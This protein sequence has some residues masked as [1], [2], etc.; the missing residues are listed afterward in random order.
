MLRVSARRAA[1][2]SGP[3]AVWGMATSHNVFVL[4]KDECEHS[5]ETLILGN[6]SIDS[7]TG[8]KDWRQRDAGES[9]P[10]GAAG[11]NSI[12]IMIGFVLGA[13]LNQQSAL[14]RLVQQPRTRHKRNHPE[15]RLAISVR[16]G[17]RAKAVQADRLGV[18]SHFCHVSSNA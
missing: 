16:L 6:T 7:W 12:T 5:T 10:H 8:I 13:T 14:A 18:S 15:G 17:H 11:C 2:A 9:E 3:D 1:K 4:K